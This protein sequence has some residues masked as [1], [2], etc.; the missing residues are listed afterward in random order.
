MTLPIPE[1]LHLQLIAVDHESLF[2]VVLYAYA[3][4]LKGADRSML[5]RGVLSLEY[6]PDSDEVNRLRRQQIRLRDVGAD[7][8]LI[9]NLEA[10][11]AQEHG[12]GRSAANLAG[13]SLEQVRDAGIRWSVL[14]K[15]GNPIR[16]SPELRGLLVKLFPDSPHDFLSG[17]EDPVDA[18]KNPVFEASP[19]DGAG[20]YRDPQAV[21]DAYRAL[22]FVNRPKLDSAID[23]VV[24]SGPDAE[25]TATWLENDFEALTSRYEFAAA[26]GLGLQFRYS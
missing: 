1:Q 25:E 11:I 8:E 21:L 18:E 7:S 20:A 5:H 23:T 2:N 22:S 26:K 6:R 10:Q 17:T 16:I 13:R 19:W 15:R 12:E 24:G 9:D 3:K 4:V 14:G